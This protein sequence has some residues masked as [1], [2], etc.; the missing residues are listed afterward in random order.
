MQRTTGLINIRS[1]T[2]TGENLLYPNIRI[3]ST[4]VELSSIKVD[5]YTGYYGEP[6]PPPSLTYDNYNKITLNQLNYEDTATVTYYS[7]AYNLGTAK[8]MYVKD[9]GEYV[10]KIS[11][12]DKYVE[13]NVYVSS[14][15]LAG[16]PTK[17]ID[18]D[19]YNKLTLIDAGSNVS[20]NVTYFSN[21]Y[22]LGSANVLYINGAGTYDLEMSGSNVFALSSN[23][24]GTVSQHPTDVVPS[25]TFDNYNKLSLGNLTPNSSSLRFGSNTYDIGTASNVYIEDAGTYK[26]ATGDAT[27]FALVSNVVTGTPSQHPTDVVPSL[28]YDNANKL[29]IEN[30]TPTSTTLTDPNGSSFDIGTASNV[31]IR[32]S[33]TYS[34]ASKDANTFVLASHTVTGTPTGTTYVYDSNTFTTPSQTYDT[35]KT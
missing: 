3:N 27:T 29:S 13:S 11:G 26:V 17:P 35:T 23:V 22:E 30:L 8:T 14:V 9:T 25:L 12:T 31:Y 1:G 18:F 15:D 2:Y 34:I 20:A 16:A 21:T 7:N 4:N 28:T 5:T 19:G 33:G 32:D 24:V 6:S 10:F